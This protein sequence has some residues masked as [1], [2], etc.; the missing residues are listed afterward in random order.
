M[1]FQLAD[2]FPNLSHGLSNIGFFLGAGASQKAGY[3]LMYELTIKVL[4]K[5]KSEEI[6]LLDGLVQRS[7]GR[8]TDKTRGE[9]NIEI[10]SDILEAAIMSID[11][12]HVDH[13][14]MIELRS[15]IRQHIVDVLLDVKNPKLD[16]HIRF[17]S[18][19]NRLLSGRSEEVWLFTPNYEL[20]F[21]IAS[22]IAHFPLVDGFLG[23]A[24]RFFNINSLLFQCGT[25]EGHRFQPFAQPTIR[26]VKLHGSLDWWK[27][28]RTIYSTQ[29]AGKLQ[30]KPERV[31]V[32]PRKKKITETLEP[33][34]DDLFRISAR[35][36]GANCKYL[37]SCGYGFGDQHINE[38]LLLPKLQQSKITLTAFIKED[39]GNIDQFRDLPAFAF[40]TAG[41]SKKRNGPIENTGSDLWQFDKLVDLLAHSAGI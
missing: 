28:D 18:A 27:R 20:L 15:A 19:L 10:I 30:G 6:A 32:L 34:F 38:T 16:D 17:F 21:E 9:P 39:S 24:V 7:L 25:V 31:I 14:K 13:P 29:D 11:V 40:G 12:K 26:L 1:S 2:I 4:D 36:L 33:P 3:P 8:N 23:A 41:S 35:I 22:S 37:V 5:L